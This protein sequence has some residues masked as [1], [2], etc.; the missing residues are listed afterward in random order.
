[1]VL[2]T[3]NM[4]IVLFSHAPLS[5]QRVIAQLN[6]GRRNLKDLE[7]MQITNFLSQSLSLWVLGIHWDLLG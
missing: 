7:S 1:M 6:S 5:Q 4:I 2:F 3:K